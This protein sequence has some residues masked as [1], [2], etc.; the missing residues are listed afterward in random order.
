M[1]GIAVIKQTAGTTKMVV[2]AYLSDLSDDDLLK[3]PA[4]G[5][6]HIAW[7]LGHL[8]AAECD[9]LNGVRPG[10]APELPAG[11]VEAHSKETSSSDDASKFHSKAEYMTLWE[12]VAAATN[13]VLDSMT[14]ADLDAPAPERLREWFPTVGAVMVL[15]ATHSLMHAGQWVPVRRAL[16]KPVVI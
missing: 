8:I 3:R 10:A 4:P 6:N 15:I 5:C 13:N 16:G 9:M 12:S 2:D 11:F 1:N 14:D 7:Q